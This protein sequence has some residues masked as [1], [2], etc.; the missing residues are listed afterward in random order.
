MRRE[1]PLFKLD[2][3][4]AAILAL[5]P[6]RN[7]IYSNINKRFINMV[8]NGVL[9]EVAKASNILENQREEGNKAAQTIHGLPELMLYL[10]GELTLEKAIETA[11]QNT[12]NYAKRQITW[13]RNKFP[14]ISIFA[15]REQIL[16]HVKRSFFL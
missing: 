1:A 7:K 15:E 9:E 2:Y 6:E 14:G 10:K 5:V 11:Q 3:D 13:F 8:E 16:E 12:R 4:Y